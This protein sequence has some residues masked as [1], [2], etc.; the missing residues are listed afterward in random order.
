[1]TVAIGSGPPSGPS[2]LP[3]CGQMWCTLIYWVTH[4]ESRGAANGSVARA[5]RFRQETFTGASLRFAQDGLAA[6]VENR[7]PAG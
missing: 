6:A 5:N 4:G 1:M 2:P 7:A 3:A